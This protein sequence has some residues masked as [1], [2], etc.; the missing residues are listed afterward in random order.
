MKDLL[1]FYERFNIGRTQLARMLKISTKSLLRYEG[2]YEHECDPY[3]FMHSKII[4]KIERGVYLIEAYEYI[5]EKPCSR[6]ENELFESK[7]K[8][9][10]EKNGVLD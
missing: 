6:I 7:V 10:L 8:V 3:E 4:W 9:L 5:R 2:C 1:D